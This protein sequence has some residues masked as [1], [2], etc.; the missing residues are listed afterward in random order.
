MLIK[1]QTTNTKYWTGQAN[2]NPKVLVRPSKSIT[3]LEMF[4]PCSDDL[5]RRWLQILLHDWPG[6]LG[7][8]AWP[9]GRSNHG[10]TTRSRVK[11]C[12]DIKLC[13]VGRDSLGFKSVYDV[14][15]LK[16]NWLYYLYWLRT[17]ST[18]SGKTNRKHLRCIAGCVF[19]LQLTKC[20]Q[21]HLQPKLESTLQKK[22]EKVD[23]FWGASFHVTVA[24]PCSM[25]MV[26]S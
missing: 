13:R 2:K 21:F 14:R 1:K 22:V 9:I 12:H 6:Q 8:Q 10:V 7:R 24:S 26:A 18:V 3:W 25:W 15:N 19:S 20:M 17:E 16:A 23:R 4:W 11:L 5:L